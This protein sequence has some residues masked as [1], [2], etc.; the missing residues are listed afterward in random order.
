[1]NKSR[2][3]LKR[4]ALLTTMLLLP[5]LLPLLA[6][7][8]V[9]SPKA[10]HADEKYNFSPDRKYKAS[11]SHGKV[12][13]RDPQDK[14]ISEFIPKD[15][16]GPNTGITDLYWIDN[17]RLG[18][19]LHMN[20]S[21]DYLSLTDVHGKQLGSYLGYNFSWSQNKKAV[22]HVGHMIHFTDWPHSEYIQVNDRTVYPLSGP[23]YGKEAK[24]VHNFIPTFA[25]SSD[26]SKLALIDE[27][28]GEG[29]GKFLV[30][31]PVDSPEQSKQFKIL[32]KQVASIHTL[33]PNGI[34]LTWRGNTSLTVSTATGEKCKDLPFT[35]NVN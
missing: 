34:K 10:A 17:N 26:D 18:I 12:S 30:I 19:Q 27:V 2:H 5:T 21:M 1:M 13:I 7:L 3:N 22:A 16:A 15:S 20:P 25:W 6:L 33:H 23:A 35:I 4:P 8:L 24:A 11:Y 32:P 29:A 9:L 28:E 14:L 31:I